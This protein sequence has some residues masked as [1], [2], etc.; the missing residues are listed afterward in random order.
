MHVR[1][2]EVKD[3]NL[4]HTFESAQPITF[5]GD[6]DE[7]TNSLVYA[8]GVHIINVMHRQQKATSRSGRITLASRDI[9]Y[10]ERH[11]KEKFRISDNL[12][13]IYKKI[14]TDSFMHESIS[15]YRGMRL[16]VNDPWETT[17]LFI[18]SQFNNVKRIRLIAKNMIDR[19]GAPIK[20]DMDSVVAKSFPTSAMLAQATQAEIFAC[21]TGFRDKYLKEAADFC[22][23]NINL[24]SLKS[25]SY[26]EIKD[27]LMEISG[28][29]DKVAD[30]IAL[31]GYGK[32]EACP[33]DVWMKRI[34]ENV[35]FKGRK[36]RISKLHEFAER[37][38]GKYAG[39]AQQYLFWNG[40]GSF[41][42]T[43]ARRDDRKH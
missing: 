14:D 2:F 12:D 40:R 39:Y 30:C 20:D 34:L 42:A 31:M 17:A 21:G 15:K 36:Q 18:I 28:V 35:Y 25:K 29:G 4:K 37:R 22:T 27:S 11:F 26:S 23:Y 6:Y 9:N 24:D 32:T 1:E 16:T 19:F 13:R 7:R 10:A 38:W 8:E 33:I 43:V 41:T 5:C 3:F